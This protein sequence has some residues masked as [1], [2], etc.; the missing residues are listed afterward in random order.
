MHSD[1]ILAPKFM[2]G[3]LL[4]RIKFT[5][6]CTRKLDPNSLVDHNTPAGNHRRSVFSQD[7]LANWLQRGTPCGLSSTR[8]FDL[9]MVRYTWECI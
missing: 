5:H 7:L 6:I 1:A 4:N 9:F 3:R 2:S 8:P